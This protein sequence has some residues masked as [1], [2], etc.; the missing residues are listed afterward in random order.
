MLLHFMFCAINVLVLQWLDLT[1]WS[2][3]LKISEPLVYM[4]RTLD[5]NRTSYHVG[6]R[7][8][9]GGWVGGGG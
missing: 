8:S 5:A 7:V 4:Y 3:L 6:V 1:V 9:V 2:I